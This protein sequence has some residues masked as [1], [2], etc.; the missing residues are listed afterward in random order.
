MAA[1]AD[2]THASEPPP[3]AVVGAEQTQLHTRILRL[4]LGV[5]ES[6]A[7]WEHVDPSVPA[8][9]RAARAF[10]ERWF[11]PKSVERVKLL[12]ANCAVRYDAYPGALA[13]L[14]A[15]SRMDGVTRALVCH[16]HLQLADPIYRRFSG[17]FLTSRRATPGTSDVQRD[18]VVRW[19]DRCAPGRWGTATVIQFASKLLS[20]AHEAGLLGGTRD[21]RPLILPR[22]SDVAL[23]YCLHLLREVQFEGS[24]LDNPYLASVGLGADVVE[25][26]LRTVPGV[27]HRRMGALHELE[28]DAA[29][30]AE[31]AE[32]TR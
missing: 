7:Y 10:E 5:E 25:A 31:W 21:P 6:R 3:A 26:R 12:I 13:E 18:V 24:L 19:V 22:V 27:R 9:E 2:R 1:V 15:W 4:A 14:R 30:L 32:A 28:W 11:G 16:W 8:T 23:G 17:E 20:A 29:S